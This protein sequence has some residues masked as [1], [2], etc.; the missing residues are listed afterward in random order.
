M[1]EAAT[2]HLSEGNTENVEELLSDATQNV[3]EAIA[4]I[5]GAREDAHRMTGR[6]ALDTELLDMLAPEEEPRMTRTEL[7]DWTLEKNGLAEAMELLRA[8]EQPTLAMQ[9]AINEMRDEQPIDF[10]WVL[11]VHPALQ[12]AFARL[13]LL[14]ANGAAATETDLREWMHFGMLPDDVAA[15]FADEITAACDAL[16]E[17]N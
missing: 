3:Y 17:G 6:V 12:A 9:R 10:G 11:S 2:F 5:Q 4:Q 15:R 7:L 1:L 16:E 13:E 8:G 14:D